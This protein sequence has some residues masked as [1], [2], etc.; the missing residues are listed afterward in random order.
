MCACQ[1]SAAL[2]ICAECW[3]HKYSHFVAFTFNF[4]WWFCRN[5]FF[6]SFF[7]AGRYSLIFFRFGCIVVQPFGVYFLFSAGISHFICLALLYHLH[8]LFSRF[9]NSRKKTTKQAKKLHVPVVTWYIL[10]PVH[11]IP[12]MCIIASQTAV[13]QHKKNTFKTELY[14]F[15]YDFLSMCSLIQ[16]RLA[17]VKQFWGVCNVD[18]MCT[19]NNLNNRKTALNT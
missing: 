7:S 14:C 12:I 8:C 18:D 2:L 4:R 15:S 11:Y 13:L 9:Y 5:F 10:W 16:L 19:F 17:F 3:L 1:F 6:A